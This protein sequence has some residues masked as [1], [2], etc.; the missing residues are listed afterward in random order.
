[1]IEYELR[2]SKRRTLSIEVNREAK[3][4]VHAPLTMPL[5]KVESFIESHKKW[6]EE[7][8]K[9]ALQNIIPEPTDAEIEL[10]KQ[11]AKDTLVPLTEY[12]AKIMGV[13]YTKVSI[14]SAKTRY[15]K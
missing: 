10:L 15:G 7:K 8:Q 11:Q 14:T 1:M 6:I 13:E 3:L 9:K 12:Y 4:V 5:Y 2:R